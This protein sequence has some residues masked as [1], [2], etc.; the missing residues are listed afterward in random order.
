M[1]EFVSPNQGNKL[2]SLLC[3]I[4]YPQNCL[5]IIITLFIKKNYVTIWLIYSDVIGLVT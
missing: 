1:N 5:H 4:W 2:G 3:S